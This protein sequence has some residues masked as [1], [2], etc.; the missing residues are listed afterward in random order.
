MKK[1]HSLKKTIDAIQSSSNFAALDQFKEQAK[2]KELEADD[3]KRL[4]LL[5][6]KRGV[7][8]LEE[9]HS[10]EDDFEMALKLASYEL[11][12]FLNV[13]KAWSRVGKIDK[14]ID[15]IQRAL[16]QKKDFAEGWLEL[17]HQ[18]SEKAYALED[19]ELM[20]EALNAFKM[21]ERIQPFALPAVY[22]EWG[23]CY[24]WLARQSG[25]ACDFTE[26]VQKFLKAESLGGVDKEIFLSHGHA[27]SELAHLMG[28]PDIIQEA[29]SMYLRAVELDSSCVEGWIH[30]GGVYKLLYEQGVSDDYFEKAESA[31][32]TC[33][34]L[35]PQMRALWICWGQLLLNEGKLKRNPEILQLSV[36]KF[37]KAEALF[38]HDPEILCFLAD[39][40]IVLGFYEEKYELIRDAKE[41]I[42]LALTFKPDNPNFILLYATC[43]HHMG[44]YFQDEKWIRQSFE[45][46]EKAI[47]LNPTDPKIWDALGVAHYSLGEMSQDP[48]MLEK[49]S[50]IFENASR[51][52]KGVSPALMNN[53]G[54]ALMKLSEITGDLHHV[55]IAADKFEQ[56]IAYHTKHLDGL[57]PDPEWFYNYGCALDYLGDFYHDPAFYE[58][59]VQILAQLL[60]HFP[61]YHQARYNLALS[62]THFGDVTA[63]MECL[64][65]AL[66]HFEVLL[67]EEP[68][69]EVVLCDAAITLLTMGDLQEGSSTFNHSKKHFDEAEEKLLLA[70]IHGSKAAFYWLACLY[71]LTGNYPESIHYLEKSHEADSLPAIEDLLLEEWLLGVRATTSFKKFIASINPS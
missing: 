61:T 10:P 19:E 2:L 41:K 27:L 28:R 29:L 67:Q 65:Q 13:A 47:S 49:A 9:D 4:S 40:L 43:L 34:R 70:I 14:A 25:E 53:W 21:A 20:F 24:L 33:A 55:Q 63:D 3:L 64:E 26:A 45:K 30:V 31:F 18:L 12:L 66:Q 48:I 23:K 50:Q 57:N 46:Y 7:K 56:A 36:Q 32:V 1:D 6:F 17:A 8:D 69:D 52:Y 39:S 59:S 51:L 22:L 68:E 62:L 44:R 71:S 38:K 35:D 60:T 15:F 5:F 42:E 16:N 54:V 58:K 11:P 37:E